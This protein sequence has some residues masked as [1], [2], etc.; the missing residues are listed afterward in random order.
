VRG[1]VYLLAAG[2]AGLGL[3]FVIAAGQG[4][5]PVR[6]TI[7]VVLVA[8]AGVVIYLSRIRPVI[9]KKEVTV[10]QDVHLSGDVR[11]EEMIC[12]Q[13]GA[14][15]EPKSVVVEAGAVFIACGYC[16]SRYQIEEAPKW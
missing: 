13:C 14:R 11:T 12:K 4:N 3:L 5:A 1:L 10:R 16:G 2:L 6:F 7:G 9:E 8:A 15:L